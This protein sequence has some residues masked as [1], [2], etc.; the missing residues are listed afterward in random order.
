MIIIS[1]QHVVNRIYYQTAE[2]T[3]ESHPS[4]NELQSTTRLAESL[5]LQIVDKR[6]RFHCPYRNAVIDYSTPTPLIIKTPIMTSFS[7]CTNNAMT[8]LPSYVNVL[9]LNIFCAKWQCR[10]NYRIIPYI[11]ISIMYMKSF[12]YS[13]WTSQSAPLSPGGWDTL[14]WDNISHRLANFG[15]RS[16]YSVR[17]SYAL[18]GLSVCGSVRLCPRA[19]EH[20]RVRHCAHLHQT[21]QTS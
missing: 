3:R 9:T 10:N 20:D 17:N 8:P 6:M 7:R 18:R 14:G 4:V 11:I 21:W 2:W 16:V 13:I 19:H 12:I 1:V 5:M 15:Y